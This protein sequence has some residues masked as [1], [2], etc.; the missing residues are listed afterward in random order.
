MTDAGALEGLVDRY[1]ETYRHNEIIF[2]EGENTPAL[3]IV[4][5]GQID[6]SVYVARSG[7]RHTLRQLR[8]GDFFGESSCFS[9]VAHSA[10]A[11]AET[12]ATVIRLNR[13]AALALM[14]QQPEIALRIIQTLGDRVRLTTDTLTRA[15]ASG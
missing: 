5:R 11:I 4:V 9:G 3:F 2:H 6:L 13:D 7:L 15:L 1:G 10:T 8:P 14:R 12:D